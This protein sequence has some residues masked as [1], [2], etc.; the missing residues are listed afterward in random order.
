MIQFEF[1]CTS[2]H[3]HMCLFV[4]KREK[5]IKIKK[6]HTFN[7]IKKFK[8]YSIKTHIQMFIHC[9]VIVLSPFVVMTMNASKIL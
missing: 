2:M 3:T 7:P 6:K 1:S 9:T 8:M 5:P 4:L